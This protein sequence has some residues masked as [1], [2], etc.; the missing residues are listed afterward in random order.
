M[1]ERRRRSLLSYARPSAQAGMKDEAGS[2]S[3][4]TKLGLVDVTFWPMHLALPLGFISVP[5]TPPQRLPSLIT[6]RILLAFFEKKQEE[7][8][9]VRWPHGSG[10]ASVGHS[11]LKLRVNS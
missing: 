7:R 1:S 2:W 6:D 8:R 4:M 5:L 9:E 10:S 3:T 11:S